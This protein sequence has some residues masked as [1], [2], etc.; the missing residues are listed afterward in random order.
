MLLRSFARRTSRTTLFAV[1]LFTPWVVSTP[2]LAAPPAVGIIS[3]FA[4]TGTRG[5][6]GDSGAATSAQM[7]QPYGVAVDIAGNVYIADTRNHRIRKVAAGSGVITTVAG[8]VIAGFSGDGGAATAARLNFPTGVAVNAA[9][10]LFV[11]DANNDRIR[12]ISNGV[13]S[14][15]AGSSTS[16]Y[17]GDGGVATAAR[18]NHP[19]AVAVDGADNLYIADQ[20]N[21]RLRKVAA[22]TGSCRPSLATQLFPERAAATTVMV[23][24]PVPR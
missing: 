24:R 10:D 13:I 20:G 2:A 14:T 18:S 22:G 16:G 4:G 9:G 12:K 23:W 3:T 1:G 8:S 15:V 21:C 11:A 17:G 6:S 5:F 7:A 19:F